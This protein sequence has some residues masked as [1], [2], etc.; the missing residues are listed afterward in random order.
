MPNVAHKQIQKTFAARKKRSAE[1]KTPAAGGAMPAELRGYVLTQALK[2]GTMLCAAFNTD[3]C[4]NEDANC[5]GAHLCAVV[6]QSGRACG[7]KHAAKDCRARRALTAE[8]FQKMQPAPTTAKAELVQLGP[9]SAGNGGLFLCVCIYII[10]YI[11]R[12]KHLKLRRFHV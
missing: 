3:R 5:E 6:L 9:F 4:Y 10:I 12:H 7:G 2:S 1:Q 8:R 11:Y